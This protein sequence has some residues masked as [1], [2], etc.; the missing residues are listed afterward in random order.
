MIERLRSIRLTWPQLAIVAA[1]SALAT[2]LIIHAA[3]RG[4][5]LSST[6]LGALRQRVAVHT[7]A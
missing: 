2:A 1:A 5:H 6:E 7:A 4:Q 3:T